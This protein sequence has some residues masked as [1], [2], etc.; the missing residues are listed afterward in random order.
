[1]PGRD[2]REA[3]EAFLEPL[4]DTISCVAKAKIILSHDDWGRDR[5]GPCVNREQ[6][7]ARQAEVPTYAH[8]AD[9]DAL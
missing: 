3:V 8:A 7:P 5:T 4:K 2:P 9:H 6:R 1:L